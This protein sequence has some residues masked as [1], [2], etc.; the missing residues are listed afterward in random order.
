[1]AIVRPVVYDGGLQRQAFPGDVL[2]GGEFL[3]AL[4]TAGA[5]TLTAALMVSGIIN[6]TGPGGAYNDTTDTAQN[7]INAIMAQYNFSQAPTTGISAG[8]AV[9]NGTTFRLKIINTVAFV[10]TMVAGTGVT[11]VGTTTIAASSIKDYLITVT[12][13]TPTQ[14]FAVTTTN[15][16]AVITGMTQFQTSQLSVGMLV[17]GTG[18]SGNIISIQPGVGV[19]LSANASATGTLVAV[20]FAPTVSI[21]SMGQMLL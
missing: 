21:T 16:S 13:G 17:T 8:T 19:T 18:V 3:N 2:A 11:L 14:V 1:M 6:R 15:A 5:G 7:I 9:P 4:T 10:L 20:T 12:N